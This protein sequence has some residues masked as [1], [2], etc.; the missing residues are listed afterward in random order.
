ML[1]SLLK[2]RDKDLGDLDFKFYRNNE[3][4]L[5]NEG[6]RFVKS[7]FSKSSDFF[8]KVSNLTNTP[9]LRSATKTLD[10]VVS[11]AYL[12]LSFPFSPDF[13]MKD[14]VPCHLCGSPIEI[15]MS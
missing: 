5:V 15:I 7:V 3:N 1:H 9:T 10:M 6:L 12:N 8:S 14:N 13:T 4:Q 2:I 11:D